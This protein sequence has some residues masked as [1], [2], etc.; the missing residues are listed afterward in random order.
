MDMEDCILL[1]TK[2]QVR[3]SLLFHLLRSC[4]SHKLLDFIY[5]LEL[6]L[7]MFSSLES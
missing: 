6:I 5:I 2:S 4:F 1:P 7:D 3:A